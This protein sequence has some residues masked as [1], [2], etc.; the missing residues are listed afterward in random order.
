MDL[1]RATGRIRIKAGELFTDTSWFY[2]FEGMGMRPS[3]H[4]PMLDV[5]SA[6]E[7]AR[8]L[9]SLSVATAA[10][11]QTAPSHDSYFG[12]PEQAVRQAG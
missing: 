9:R 4:D 5:V 1:Y 10:A 12:P 7:L 11:A 3:R 8:I 2:I 6:A